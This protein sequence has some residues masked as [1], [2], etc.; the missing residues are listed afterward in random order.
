MGR[1]KKACEKFDLAA[2]ARLTKDGADLNGEIPSGGSLL[3]FACKLSKPEVALKLLE[4]GAHPIAMDRSG[5]S[6]LE[7]ACA[8]GWTSVPAAL[9]KAQAKA[10]RGESVSI[11]QA[12][13]WSLSMQAAMKAAHKSGHHGVVEA[14]MNSTRTHYGERRMAAPLATRHDAGRAFE[15]FAIFSRDDGLSDLLALRAPLNPSA[16]YISDRA[17]RLLLKT[18]GP[19]P[20]PIT[21]VLVDS[22]RACVGAMSK[23]LSDG[24]VK[25]TPMATLTPAAARIAHMMMDS[26]SELENSQS[27]APPSPAAKLA[28]DW[29]AKLSANPGAHESELIAWARPALDAAGSLAAQHMLDDFLPGP[30]ARSMASMAAMEEREAS[31]AEAAKL[32]TAA[33]S[34]VLRRHIEHISRTDPAGIDKEY[35][36][37]CTDRIE[38]ALQFI[39]EPLARLWGSRRIY[40][41]DR[42]LVDQLAQMELPRDK[43][44]HSMIWELARRTPHKGLLLRLS[45]PRPCG[46][47]HADFC[48]NWAVSVG[49]SPAGKP[50]LR[51]TSDNLPLIGFGFSFALE[52]TESVGDSCL[53][54]AVEKGLDNRAWVASG[55]LSIMERRQGAAGA[56]Q[57]HSPVPAEWVEFATSQAR[58][59]INAFCYSCC[60]NADIHRSANPSPHRSFSNLALAKAST[61]APPNPNVGWNALWLGVQFGDMARQH[62]SDGDNDSGRQLPPGSKR[63]VSP[64]PRVAHWRGVWVGPRNGIQ[65]LKA[66]WV[67]ATFVGAKI[68][69]DVDSHRPRGARVS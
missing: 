17:A 40:N 7:I 16:P 39:G 5:K 63:R 68:S 47:E 6:A 61:L 29:F 67:D 58:L 21:G 42:E 22:E 35:A 48:V 49:V 32:A 2:I 28:S 64:H 4:L 38:R 26:W 8:R 54:A 34:A 55:M 33:D 30:Q 23:A 45:S 10:A 31:H 60:S 57:A 56:D 18:N 9:A 20:Y 25:S 59:A 37:E 65:T 66:T 62:R 15:A 52:L 44:G 69:A 51:I 53:K 13:I 46:D 12:C 27:M 41:I 19:I 3:A 43:E 50:E 14:F 11:L 36:M 1:I 24:T